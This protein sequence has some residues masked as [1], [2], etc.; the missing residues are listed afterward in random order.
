MSA[1]HDF[2]RITSGWIA[3]GPTELNDRVLQAALDEV[4]VTNQRRRLAGPWRAPALNTPLRL[5]AAIAILA[6]VGMAGLNLFRGGGVGGPTS[7]PFA[8]PT[9]VPSATLP[10]SAPASAARSFPTQQSPLTA[11]IY[12]A[13]SPFVLPNLTFDV[14]TEWNAWAGVTTNAISLE[15]DSA[16]QTGSTG[17]FVNFEVPIAVY[18]DPCKTGDRVNVPNLG[19]TVD[20]FV[21]AVSRLPK[22]TA[23]PVTDTLVDGLPGKQFDLTNIIPADNAGCTSAQNS[24]IHVWDT[25]AGFGGDTLGGLR[26]HVVVVDVQG[27]RFVVDVLYTDPSRPIE[28][29]V[30]AIIASIHFE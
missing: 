6:V 18:A 4:H 28:N 15:I 19:P 5:A 24:V 27:T 30:N 29:D 1:R 17:A 10:S 7:T 3:E 8:S 11:G 2:D 25:N 14:P 13:G 16:T 26:Q 21:T 9:A 12:R 22:F 20:D 23:G